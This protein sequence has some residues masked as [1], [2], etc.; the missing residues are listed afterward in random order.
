MFF[1]LAIKKTL[2]E[3]FLIR[4]AHGDLR[5]VIRSENPCAAYVD[6]TA[7]YKMVLRTCPDS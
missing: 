3:S 7:I 1:I 2:T 4:L 5:G 6:A